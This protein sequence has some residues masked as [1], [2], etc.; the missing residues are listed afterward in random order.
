MRFLR[1]RRHGEHRPNLARVDAAILGY[2]HLQVNQRARASGEVIERPVNFDP[3]SSVNF[4]PHL[5]ERHCDLLRS[6]LLVVE[7][8]DVTI[9][10]NLLLELLYVTNVFAPA[11]NNAAPPA[12]T[13]P[14]Q[15]TLPSVV[16]LALKQDDSIKLR[17]GGLV[18]LLL[19]YRNRAGRAV[20]AEACS[21][22]RADQADVDVGLFHHLKA[23]CENV[24]LARQLV[25][26]ALNERPA[27]GR[28][29][30][31]Y[32]APVLLQVEVS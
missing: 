30:V 8:A 16:A 22:P 10:Q 15:P 29:R 21:V 1:N 28:E 27:E 23:A 3:H 13:V 6:I 17:V 11:L 9:L 31:A 14:R 18:E 32:L 19:G 2:T 26:H 12:R 24:A 4:I 20:A 5:L 7:V 25:L